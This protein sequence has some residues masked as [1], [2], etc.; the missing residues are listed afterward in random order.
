FGLSLT[1]PLHQ[2][3]I[4]QPASQRLG[5]LIRLA[6]NEFL[7]FL[8]TLPILGRTPLADALPNLG[9]RIPGIVLRIPNRLPRSF[10]IHVTRPHAVPFHRLGLSHLSLPG[11]LR[12]RQRASSLDR[13]LWTSMRK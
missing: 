3:V 8:P 5:L 6:T 11:R 4:R 7:P 9:G 1:L 2:F 13:S 10:P 12:R